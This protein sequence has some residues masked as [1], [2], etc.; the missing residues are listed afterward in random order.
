MPNTKV[1]V[2]IP[3]WNG[4]DVLSECLDSLG[5][6]NYKNIEII[7]V[8]NASSDGSQDWIRSNHPNIILVQNKSNLGYAEGCNVGAK[9]S[10]GEYLIFL[11]NDTVQN[12]NW[13]ESLVD[14]LNLNRNVA[15]VQ[16]K[17]LN[18]FDR[19]KFDYAGGCGGW[20]DVLGFPF[21]RGRLFLNLE[22]DEG[23]YEKIR[24]IFW[25]SGTA[26]MIRKKMFIDLNGFDKTFF[27][28]QEEIDLCWKIHLSGKEV[29]SVPTSVVFH[30]NA[31]TLPMFSR[32]KQYLNHRNSLL[33]M[34]TNYSLPMTLYLFPIRLYLEFVALFYALFCFDISHFIGIIQ[35]LLWIITHPHIIVSRRIRTRKIRKLKDAKIIKNMYW[36]SVVF[37][38]YIRRKKKSVDLIKE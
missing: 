27:A 11:N 26:L 20:I 7:V 9:S 16:P 2:I 24:P 33:M 10:S 18:Y 35:S 32:K 19:T 3:H 25:A 13:I 17:I 28:H 29:W 23:Q 31:V 36:G 21:A 34:L 30:K 12:E 6:S 22:K 37:D 4:I 15:A 5:K 38:H 14:F 1:S 8:D